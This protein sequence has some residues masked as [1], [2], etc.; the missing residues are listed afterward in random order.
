MASG[1]STLFRHVSPHILRVFHTH[2][3]HATVSPP[4]LAPGFAECVLEP[5]RIRQVAARRE[6]VSQHLVQKGLRRLASLVSLVW[7]VL[8]RRSTWSR[9]FRG[10]HTLQHFLSGCPVWRPMSR[11]GR[12]VQPD[13]PLGSSCYRIKG[14][15]WRVSSRMSCL[16]GTRF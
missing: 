9:C 16:L 1:S 11:V 2:A 12:V 10:R 3:A 4:A 7:S 15:D 6:H 8:G 13:D 14:R 5:R